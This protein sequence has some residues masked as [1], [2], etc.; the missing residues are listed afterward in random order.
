MSLVTDLQAA[1]QLLASLLPLDPPHAL[2]HYFA[3]EH[4]PRRSRL[5]VHLDSRGQPSAFVAVCQTGVDLFRPLVVL[6]GDTDGL[7]QALTVALTPGRAYLVSAQ[8]EHHDWLKS[9]VRITDLERCRV[10][11]L[12]PERFQPVLNILVQLSHTPDGL[13]RAVIHGRDGGVVAE[14]GASWMSS[15]YAEVF[16]EVAEAARGRGLGRSVVSALSARVLEMG[17]APIYVAP[18]RSTASLALAQ[19]LGYADSGAREWNG[20]LIA[21]QP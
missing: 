20:A 4:D 7:D 12:T 16:V 19:R 6:H 21:Q 10:L 13:P 11:F 2:R 18:E 14:A 8:L 1:R 3:L 9:R 17:R 5:I 15:R